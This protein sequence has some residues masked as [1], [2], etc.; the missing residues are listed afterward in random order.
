LTDWLSR[1]AALGVAARPSATRTS[2]RSASWIASRV[3]SR[4]QVEK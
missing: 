3:P 1:I 2:A 4:R